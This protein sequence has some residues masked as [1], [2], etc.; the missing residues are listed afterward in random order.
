MTDSW[1]RGEPTAVFCSA[2]CSKNELWSHLGAGIF[3]I[4]REVKVQRSVSVERHQSSIA[5]VRVHSSYYCQCWNSRACV[6]TSSTDILIV[7]KQI[8]FAQNHFQECPRYPLSCE[9]CGKE[10]IPKDEVSSFL[11]EMWHTMSDLHL[12]GTH[13]WKVLFACTSLWEKSQVLLSHKELYCHLMRQ[14]KF[15]AYWS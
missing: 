8:L 12:S 15:G 14:K 1:T 9:K 6:R 10:S 3:C 2:P 11:L 5:G 7:I 13:K 4:P